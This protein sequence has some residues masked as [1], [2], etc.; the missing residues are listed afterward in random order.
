MRFIPFLC[1][2]F[3]PK[4]LYSSFWLHG[5]FQLVWRRED[6]PTPS[7]PTEILNLFEKEK[8]NNYTRTTKFSW[9]RSHHRLRQ[10]ESTGQQTSSPPRQHGGRRSSSVW[11]LQ[12]ALM[13]NGLTFVSVKWKRQERLGFFFFFYRFFRLLAPLLKPL[14]IRKRQQ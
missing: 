6:G 9:R 14:L 8:L 2:L 1:F 12:S 11:C 5:V 13:V 7:P 3:F 10:R 4:I